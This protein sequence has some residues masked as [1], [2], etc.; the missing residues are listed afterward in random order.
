MQFISYTLIALKYKYIYIYI[1]I[2]N[3]LNN[4][5]PTPFLF[6]FFF[7]GFIEL[8][9]FVWN[10]KLSLLGHQFGQK[11]SDIHTHI[12]INVFTYPYVK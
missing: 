9:I 6:F 12:N 3:T 5:K 10:V 4:G 1:Y 11:S 2:N 8:G 7:L